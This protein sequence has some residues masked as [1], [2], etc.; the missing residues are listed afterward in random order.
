MACHTHIIFREAWS[1]KLDKYFYIFKNYK[2]VV[3][4]MRPQNG[5]ILLADHET[6]GTRTKRIFSIIRYRIR[7][8]Y[9][10]NFTR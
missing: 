8:Q 9:H 5:L 6:S 7:R 4:K 2:I 3:R 10:N 1:H